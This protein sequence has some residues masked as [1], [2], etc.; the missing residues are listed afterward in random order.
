MNV[1]FTLYA[2][3][4]I[5]VA[6]IIAIN[7]WKCHHFFETFVFDHAP[8]RVRKSKKKRQ[9]VSNP[10]PQKEYFLIMPQRL[11]KILI[12]SLQS[13][14][15]QRRKPKYILS[16]KSIFIFKLMVKLFNPG[17]EEGTLSESPYMFFEAFIVDFYVS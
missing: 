3:N 4:G 14:C 10:Q 1:A 6:I 15:I 8:N 16:V 7:I 5:M 2:Y 13:G 12:T 9:H 17:P 11:L